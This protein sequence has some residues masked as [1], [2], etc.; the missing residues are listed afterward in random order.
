M[1]AD[2]FMMMN[3][4]QVARTTTLISPNM[5]RHIKKSFNEDFA[6]FNLEIPYA[7]ELTNKS[8]ALVRI[9]FFDP[10]ASLSE[11]GMENFSFVF[12]IVTKLLPSVAV[13]SALGVLMV[14][15]K[16]ANLVFG[17][18]QIVQALYGA[19]SRSVF[20]NLPIRYLQETVLDLM[21]SGL[22][23]IRATY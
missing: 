19:I 21:L 16:G 17:R 18:F 13:I 4:I 15:G 22:L 9:D 2:V 20:F 8:L 3:T 1:G 7:A 23:S 5:N 10:D 6:M 14:F 12:V 11:Y